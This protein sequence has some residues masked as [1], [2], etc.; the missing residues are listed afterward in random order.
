M[1]AHSNGDKK[2]SR[3]R[4]QA[5]R[6]Q[7]FPPASH[8]HKRRSE[9]RLAVPRARPSWAAIVCR[10]CG[11]P[12]IQMVLPLAPGGMLARIA[13]A[14]TRACTRVRGEGGVCRGTCEERKSSHEE[15]KARVRRALDEER[16]RIA[17]ERRAQKVISEQSASGLRR[18]APLAPRPP[19]AHTPPLPPCR[20]R[21]QRRATT[22]CFLRAGITGVRPRKG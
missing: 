11:W 6:P 21:A 18:C 1:G 8:T 15:E 20:P 16:D 3:K 7:A 19:P 12:N 13:C 17:T 5:G 2:Q 9:K 10:P 4:T 14:Q 22:P